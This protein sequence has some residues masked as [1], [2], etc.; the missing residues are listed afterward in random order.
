[1]G[2][3]ERMRR[4]QTPTHLHPVPDCHK[5]CFPG[6]R[7]FVRDATRHNGGKKHEHGKRYHLGPPGRA[8]ACRPSTGR[9]TGRFPRGGTWGP[10]DSG[11]R[12]INSDGTQRMAGV[13]APF[14]GRKILASRSANTRGSAGRDFRHAKLLPANPAVP[15][16]FPVRP[17]VPS[18]GLRPPRERFGPVAVLMRMSVRA[19]PVKRTRRLALLRL[20][21]L[22]DAFPEFFGQGFDEGTFNLA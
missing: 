15:R 16:L 18:P 1:M 7:G 10:P 12:P 17:A 3:G 5:N 11:R 22:T 14:R 8:G 9:S 20:G 19:S 4:N 13:D 2:R 6:R 21:C